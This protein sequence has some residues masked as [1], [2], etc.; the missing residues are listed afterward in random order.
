MLQGLSTCFTISV[1]QFIVK[2]FVAKVVAWKSRPPYMEYN[3][4]N[5]VGLFV[6]ES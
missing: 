2:Y 3:C 1:Q 4:I 6:F 5:I